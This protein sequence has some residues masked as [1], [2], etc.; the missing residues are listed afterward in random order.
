MATWRALLLSLSAGLTAGC[1]N[2]PAAPQCTATPSEQ[3]SVNAD[4][5]TTTTGLRYIE[6]APGDGAALPWCRTVA[7]HYTGYLVDGTKFDSSRDIDRPLVFTPGLGSAIDGF[8]QG[9]IG[10]RS[11]AT[12]LLI[13][14]PELGFGAEP[15]RNDAGEIIIPGNS[16]VVFDVEVLE[17]GG[18]PVIPCAAP[19]A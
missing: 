18:E 8:E 5:I 7:V 13:I 15:R 1:I 3:A 19:N 6:G 4:T 10:M 12:R 14:P 16:T 11:C 17:I 9:V 2:A